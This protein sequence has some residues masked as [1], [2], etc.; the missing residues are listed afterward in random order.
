M[1]HLQRTL[2]GNAKRVIG[3]MLTHGHLYREALKEL[4][5]QFGY[6]ETVAGAYLKTIFTRC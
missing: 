4:E 2:D 6:E 1:T 5:E 3:G